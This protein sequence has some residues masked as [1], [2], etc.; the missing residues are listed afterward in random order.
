[1]RSKGFDYSLPG[2]NLVTMVTH[3]RE[4]LF[5][6]VLDGEMWV[7]QLGN[8]VERAWMDLLIH[9]PNV[10]MESF[11]VMPNHVHVIVEIKAGDDDY[12]RGGSQTHPYKDGSFTGGPR[13]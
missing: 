4:C 6:G 13:W 10:T 2:V 1:M 11:V 9:Y 3:Q 5:G 12:R 7:N 8:I